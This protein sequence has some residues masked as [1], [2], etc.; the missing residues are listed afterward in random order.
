MPRDSGAV[1]ATRA[2]RNNRKLVCLRDDQVK[3]H[4]LVPTSIMVVLIRCT[5]KCPKP[6]GYVTW[7]NG[8]ATCT[9]AHTN[10]GES[11]RAIKFKKV[12]SAP[13]V[14]ALACGT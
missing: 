10:A 2:P 13:H 8:N 1:I 9:V 6:S 4:T 7:V 3:N 5:T 14:Y 11:D 12:F